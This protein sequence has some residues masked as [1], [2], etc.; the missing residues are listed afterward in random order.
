M[1]TN[2]LFLDFEQATAF[3]S[4]K[5][6]DFNNFKPVDLVLFIKEYLQ[7]DS[8]LVKKETGLALD[9][10]KISWI[11]I[12]SKTTKEIYFRSLNIYSFEEW[13]FWLQN[14]TISSVP[15]ICD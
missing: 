9:N 5:I 11:Q 13:I 4:E 7:S 10:L 2:E 6:F 12:L 1:N 15:T 3:G 14:I 8:T